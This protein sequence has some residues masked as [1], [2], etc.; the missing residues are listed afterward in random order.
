MDDSGKP[1]KFTK[2]RRIFVVLLSV[3]LVAGIYFT[4]NP[5]AV[6]GPMTATEYCKLLYDAPVKIWE[7]QSPPKI[8]KIAEEIEKNQTNNPKLNDSGKNVAK[9]IYNIADAVEETLKDGISGELFSALA[10]IGV[11]GIAAT[12]L[13]AAEANVVGC[14]NWTPPSTDIPA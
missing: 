10:G 7:A 13:A 6:K 8:R 4:N 2:A 1:R 12:E 9:A 11:L 3:V 5:S 14:D